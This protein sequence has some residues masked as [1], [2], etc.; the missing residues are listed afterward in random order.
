MKKVLIA[1]SGGV[2]SSVSALLMQNQGYEC[3]GCTMKLYDNTEDDTAYE[4]TCC[5]LTDVEDAKDVCRRLG[6]SHYVF[7]FKDAFK[8]KVIDKFVSCYLCGSTPNPCIECNDHLKFARLYE[9]AQILGC[10]KIVTGHY[11]RIIERDGSYHLYTA[12]DPA[13]DQSYVL[14]RLSQEQLSHTIFPL[15]EI[16]KEETR[17]IAEENGLINARKKDSQDIC[18]IPDGDYARV[19]EEYTDQK[20]IPGDFVDLNGN[21]LGRH[22]GII[23]YTV[24]QRKGLGIAYEY[25]LYVVKI[26]VENNRVVLGPND[27]LFSDS[28]DACNA[29]WTMQNPPADSFEASVRVRYH[30]KNVPALVTMAGSDKFHVK[31]YEPV[32]AITPGQAAV[33]YDGDEVLGGGTIL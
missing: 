8:E 27:A 13:K 23:H 1:M 6:I 5:T 12:P 11:A 22:K 19:V 33:I 20:I 30:G 4:K 10:D 32:R 2:D 21:V 3:I 31:F 15:G 9:K 14:Y 26:D 28:L 7:N 16:S 18:F 25:P 29:C 24:G 17:R